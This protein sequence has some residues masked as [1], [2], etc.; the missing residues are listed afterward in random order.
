[1]IRKRHRETTNKGE[2]LDHWP[3]SEALVC[4]R[5]SRFLI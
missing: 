1:M 3:L 2:A 4:A 5:S